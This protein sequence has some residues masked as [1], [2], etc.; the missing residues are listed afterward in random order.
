[1]VISSLGRQLWDCSLLSIFSIIHGIDVEV[2][3]EM[4][5]KFSSVQH[6]TKIIGFMQNIFKVRSSPIS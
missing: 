4:L 6:L 3:Q 2:S 1:M 5:R